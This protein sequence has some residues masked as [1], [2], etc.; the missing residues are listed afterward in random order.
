MPQAVKVTEKA[1][2][3]IRVEDLGKM[4]EWIAWSSTSY[5]LLLACTDCSVVRD[6]MVLMVCGG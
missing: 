2:R 3:M 5:N 4:L 1:A 6:S